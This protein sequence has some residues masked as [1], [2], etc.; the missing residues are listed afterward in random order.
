MAHLTPNKQQKGT[1]AFY[2]RQLYLCP[3]LR[4]LLDSPKPVSPKPDSPKPVSPKPDLPKPVSPK[5]GFRVRLRLRF[6]VRVQGQGQ[7]WR[8]GESGFGE[9]GLNHFCLFGIQS[10]YLFNCSFPS[11]KWSETY[12]TTL[13]LLTSVIFATIQGGGCNMHFYRG[14]LV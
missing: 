9:S 2:S 6:R 11:T 14:L 10:R 12:T 4:C 8:F 5:L 13:I 1:S 7:G 3:F